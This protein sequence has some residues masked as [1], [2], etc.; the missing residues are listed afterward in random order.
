MLGLGIVTVKG[1]VLVLKACSVQNNAPKTDKAF[2]KGAACPQQ[3]CTGEVK[4]TGYQAF[5]PEGYS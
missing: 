3:K 4:Y 5:L 1:N 2:Q